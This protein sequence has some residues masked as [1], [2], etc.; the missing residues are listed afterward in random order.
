MKPRRGAVRQLRGGKTGRERVRG[1]ER[2]EVIEL[3]FN[4]NDSS[5]E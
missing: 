2:R 4:Q 5:E 3:K 1:V